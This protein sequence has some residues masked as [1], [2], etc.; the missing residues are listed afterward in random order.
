MAQAA[1]A[2]GI[3]NQVNRNHKSAKSG[4]GGREKKKEKRDAKSGN[5]KEKHNPRAFSVANIV[6]T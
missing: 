5:L 4:R 6:R 2:A 3:D 1:A